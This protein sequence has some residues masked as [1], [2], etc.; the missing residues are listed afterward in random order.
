[1]VLSEKLME[2]L[3]ISSGGLPLVE[4]VHVELRGCTGTCRMKEARLACL[5]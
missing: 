1:M 3:S 5:K 2:K 4:V